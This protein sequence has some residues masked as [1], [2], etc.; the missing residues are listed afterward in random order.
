M[1]LREPILVLSIP[2]TERLVDNAERQ[3]VMM[4]M[5]VNHLDR[6]TPLAID[7]CH[8]CGITTAE[9]DDLF[10]TLNIKI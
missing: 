7:V 3:L 9:W 8:A 6:H 4:R 1:H 5:I 2:V 10:D